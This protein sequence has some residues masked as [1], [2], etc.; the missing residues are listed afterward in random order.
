MVLDLSDGNSLLINHSENGKSHSVQPWR[1][2]NKVINF[3]LTRRQ[4]LTHVEF[5]TILRDLVSGEP[6]IVLLFSESFQ[7]EQ[8]LWLREVLV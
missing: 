7:E 3:L 4:I 6:Q 1:R 2:V 8:E 5:L